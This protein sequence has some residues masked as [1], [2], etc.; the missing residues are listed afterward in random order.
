[1]SDFPKK[2]R[3]LPEKQPR[4]NLMDSDKYDN[5]WIVSKSVNVLVA[6]GTKGSEYMHRAGHMGNVSRLGQVQVHSQGRDGQRK[7]H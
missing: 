3:K 2:V 4:Y 7:P 5:G 6:V 1:M